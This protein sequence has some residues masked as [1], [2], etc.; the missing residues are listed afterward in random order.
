MDDFKETDRGDR[1][2]FR[3]RNSDIRGYSVE[4]LNCLVGGLSRLWLSGEEA[5]GGVTHLIDNVT[6]ER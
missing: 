5:A 4:V 2:T 1:S 6:T 3:A